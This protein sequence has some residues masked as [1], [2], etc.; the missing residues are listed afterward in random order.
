MAKLEATYKRY[1]SA[2]KPHLKWV[3]HYPDSETQKRKR[4][5]YKTEAEAK[6]SVSK[7][8]KSYI[9]LGEDAKNLDKEKQQEYLQCKK[10]LDENQISISLLDAVKYYVNDY[11]LRGRS[12]QIKDAIQRCIQ[13]K[14]DE[15]VS[16]VYVKAL[17]S[18][19]KRIEQDF[20]DR[21]LSDIRSNEV[22]DWIKKLPLSETSK[23]NFSKEFRTLFSWAVSNEYCESNPLTKVRKI[24]SAKKRITASNISKIEPELKLNPIFYPD[25][26]GQVLKLAKGDVKAY[27]A[28]GAFAGIRTSEIERLRWSD[29]NF[30]EGYIDLS[31]EITKTAKD[32]HVIIEPNLKDWLDGLI[33]KPTDTDPDPFVCAR[34]FDRRLRLFK[35]ELLSNG[36][37]W[38]NNVLRHSFASYSMAL[39]GDV[40]TREQLGQ[41]SPYVVH[42]HYK[43]TITKTKA[44]EWFNILPNTYYEKP[45]IKFE[46]AI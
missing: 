15:G 46:R 19:F 35:K 17:R 6:Q 8:N 7:K 12:L 38:K 45:I 33:V 39:H 3:V 26:M 36:I 25:E 16:D 21:H 11:K 9:E 1:K 31:R 37:E 43:Q 20:G 40:R 14:I 24:K 18:R 34:G 41:T 27:I 13:D 30:I 4:A 10:L 22:K 44:E 5:F 42:R 29:F 28:I 23:N 2:S 32:R